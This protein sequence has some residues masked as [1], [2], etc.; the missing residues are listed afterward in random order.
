MKKILLVLLALTCACALQAQPFAVGDKVGG[1]VVFYITDG[2]THGLIAESKDFPDKLK[3]ADAIA[4]ANDPAKHSE[5][6]KLF[7]DWR[8]PTLAESR[9]MTQK[10]A[11]IGGITSG[12]YWTSDTQTTSRG[13][14]GILLLFKTVPDNGAPNGDTLLK[15]PAMPA[16]VRVIRSF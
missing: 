6:G 16:S 1:G 15:P 10:I 12:Y 3:R 14:V 2:G 4:L 9:L 5:Q 7:T 8:L 11:I 13:A